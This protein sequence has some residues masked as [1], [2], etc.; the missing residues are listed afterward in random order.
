MKWEWIEV[1]GHSPRSRKR[2]GSQHPLFTN[3]P[4]GAGEVRAGIGLSEDE[5]RRKQPADRP[6]NDAR[7]QTG[8]SNA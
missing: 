5:Q 8:E 2:T 3:T 4:F 7:R 6:T 1:S